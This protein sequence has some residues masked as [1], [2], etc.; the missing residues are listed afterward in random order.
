MG[1]TPGFATGGY[2]GTW[3]DNQNGRL[4]ILHQKEL[5]LNA[6]DTE[7]ILAAVDAVRKLTTN[8]RN[9][10]FEDTVSLLNKYGSEL[11]A[12]NATENNIS[13]EITV[14]ATFPNANNA[15]E[16]RSAI[17]GLAEQATQYANKNNK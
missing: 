9:G 13:Q 2:T 14:N 4:A 12:N 10:A 3:S 7:N 6:T 16:I 17:L 1:I 8:Y 15:E 11:L 5:I